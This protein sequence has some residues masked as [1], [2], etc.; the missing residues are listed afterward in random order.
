M[1]Y[2]NR[3]LY[4]PSTATY[5]S[6]DR[7]FDM[8]CRGESFDVINSSTKEPYTAQVLC[9][10][11][12]KVSRKRLPIDVAKVITVLRD[13]LTHEAGDAEE[14]AKPLA[15]QETANPSIEMGQPV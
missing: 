2:N 8:V 13:A 6:T 10:M 14:T 9:Q 11:L 3:K 4:D 15:P 5:V 7:L 12:C 1:R